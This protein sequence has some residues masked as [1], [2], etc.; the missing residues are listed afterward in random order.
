MEIKH[1]QS[2][3]EEKEFRQIKEVLPQVKLKADY[4]REILDIG[5]E[6]PFGNQIFILLKGEQTNHCYELITPDCRFYEGL[7][8]LTEVLEKLQIEIKG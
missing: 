1:F 3:S 4:N 6:I 8:T 5:V 2:A 7:R